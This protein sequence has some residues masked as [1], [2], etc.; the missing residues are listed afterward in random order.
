MNELMTHMLNAEIMINPKENVS[1]LYPYYIWE[2]EAKNNEVI[3]Y[4]KKGKVGN[5]VL[6]K[7]ILPYILE[8]YKIKD[9][10]GNTLCAYEYIDDWTFYGDGEDI[11][12]FYHNN[13]RIYRDFYKSKWA[14]GNYKE[15]EKTL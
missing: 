7:D 11:F 5:N 9:E 14:K 12:V 8:G 15:W 2:Y 4:T 10:F 1:S 6:L 3:L 13:I